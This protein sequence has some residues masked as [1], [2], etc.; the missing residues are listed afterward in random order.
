MFALRTSPVV[1]VLL[2]SSTS[3]LHTYPSTSCSSHCSR[4]PTVHPDWSSSGYLLSVPLKSTSCFQLSRTMTESMNYGREEVY[5][6]HT[7]LSDKVSLIY[8]LNVLVDHGI[9]ID[10]TV[11]SSQGSYNV[12]IRY[13]SLIK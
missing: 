5:S 11:V 8:R 4:P 7:S 9:P 1:K 2:W 12:L 13:I 6:D 10:T 3:K